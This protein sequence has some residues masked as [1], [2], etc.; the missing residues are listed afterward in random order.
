MFRIDG[1]PR[2]QMVGLHINCARIKTTFFGIGIYQGAKPYHANKYTGLERCQFSASPLW[3]TGNVPCTKNT[4]KP[5]PFIFGNFAHPLR[6]S[7]AH[8]LDHLMVSFYF[9]LGR[10]TGHV[11]D[12]CELVTDCYGWGNI[13][14]S[15]HPRHFS[16]TVGSFKTTKYRMRQGWKNTSTRWWLLRP[17]LQLD[18]GPCMTTI[19]WTWTCLARNYADKLLTFH[20]A[21]GTA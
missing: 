4:Y 7:A 1:A 6:T 15:K 12:H 17:G 5:W 9:A 16:L 20:P 18:I 11:V 13:T 10:N 2:A 21:Q 8:W 14:S 3:W 19:W